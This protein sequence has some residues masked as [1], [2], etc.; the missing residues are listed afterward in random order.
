MY[1]SEKNPGFKWD[2]REPRNRRFDWKDVIIK[3]VFLVIFLLLLLWLFP[4]V[5]NMKPFYSNVFR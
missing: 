4:K 3:A 2:E 1:S 5:P